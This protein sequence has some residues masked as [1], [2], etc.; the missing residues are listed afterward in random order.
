MHASALGASTQAG[1]Y[2]YTDLQA[3]YL[4]ADEKSDYEQIPERKYILSFP[5]SSADLD[6]MFDDS[7]SSSETPRQS[8]RTTLLTNDTGSDYEHISQ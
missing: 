7:V 8:Y 4:P 2:M 6:C 1:E 5:T 3:A